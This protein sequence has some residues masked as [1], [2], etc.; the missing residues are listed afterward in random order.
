MVPL[1]HSLLGTW[2]TTQACALTGNQTHHPLGHRPAF[3]PL[4]HTSQ[5]E[6]YIFKLFPLC[7][8]YRIS[9]NLALTSFSSDISILL[10]PSTEFFTSVVVF[11]GSKIY[12]WY[13]F[14]SSVSFP[15]TLSS[16]YFKSIH[17]YLEYFSNGYFKVFVR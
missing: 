17:L 4:S 16:F 12:I 9:F 10:S 11:F 1:A 8:D 2:P 3:N 5:A 7:S 15:E 13:L 6:R 14:I